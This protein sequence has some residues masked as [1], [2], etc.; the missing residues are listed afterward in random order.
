[1]DQTKQPN[2]EEHPTL[3]TIMKPFMDLIVIFSEGE[4]EDQCIRLAHPMIADACL[5]M[6]TEH[7]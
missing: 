7:N 3:E 1:M 5:K 4:Q 6:F 2:D